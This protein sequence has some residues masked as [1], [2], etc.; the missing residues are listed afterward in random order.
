MDGDLLPLDAT[1][2]EIEELAIENARNSS[3]TL[4][5]SCIFPQSQ[6]SSQSRTLPQSSSTLDKI[7]SKAAITKAA[8]LLRFTNIIDVAMYKDMIETYRKGL[9][10]ESARFK[11]V[12]WKRIFA[13]V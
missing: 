11:P 6:T 8:G 9:R 12:G 13:A 4:P 10:G 7:S 3:C 2:K 5:Q 1:V